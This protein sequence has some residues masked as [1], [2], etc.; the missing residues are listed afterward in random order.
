[1]AVEVSGAGVRSRHRDERPAERTGRHG[2]ATLT[3]MME[4]AC[5]APSGSAWVTHDCV[6][7]F[8]TKQDGEGVPRYLSGEKT[9]D[10]G[11]E[12]LHSREILTKNYG[13]L[14]FLGFCSG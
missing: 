3:D 11:T 9:S 8:C 5:G 14:L 1:M 13:F 10:S 4:R 7:V 12:S 6:M 2:Q